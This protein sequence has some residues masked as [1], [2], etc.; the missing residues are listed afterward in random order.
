MKNIVNYYAIEPSDHPLKIYV[1][2][3]EH[4][5]A[6]A[7]GQGSWDSDIDWEFDTEQERT[8]FALRWS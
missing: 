8:L 4:F 6:R 7:V 5:G 3:K 1:Y 2:L